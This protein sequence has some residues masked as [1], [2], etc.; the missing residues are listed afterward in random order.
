MCERPTSSLGWTTHLSAG[1]GTV[2]TDEPSTYQLAHHSYR[3]NSV[4]PFETATRINYSWHWRYA[5]RGRQRTRR[6]RY[7]SAYLASRRPRARTIAYIHNLVCIRPPM[8]FA[9]A[10]LRVAHRRRMSAIPTRDNG[11]VKVSARTCTELPDTTQTSS[12]SGSGAASDCVPV[13]L[14]TILWHSMRAG[15]RNLENSNLEASDLYEDNKRTPRTEEGEA[16]SKTES[17]FVSV[18]HCVMRVAHGACRSVRS[19]TTSPEDI[20]MDW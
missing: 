10:P 5:F 8:T 12:K 13:A 19:A 7:G 16:L 20:H 17:H 14:A 2:A 4:D 9:R 15:F 18:L 1:P 3:R 6:T 11:S